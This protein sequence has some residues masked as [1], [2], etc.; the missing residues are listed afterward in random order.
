MKTSLALF[1]LILPLVVCAQKR[2]D[3]PKLFSDKEKSVCFVGDSITH[4]GYYPKHIALYYITRYPHLEKSFLNAGFEGGSANTTNLRFNADVASKKAQIYTVMLGM[5]DVRHWNFTPKALADRKSH[6]EKKQNFFALYKHNMTKLVDSLQKIGKVVLLSSSIYDAIGDILD[7]YAVM[8]NGEIIP[9]KRNIGKQF[10]NDELNRYGQWCAQLAKERNL[11]FA[12]HWRETNAA[13]IKVVAE[14]PHSS[15]IGRNRVHPF[16]F[17]GFFTA[18]AF[19]KDL[20]ETSIVSSIEL[21]AKTGNFQTLNAEVSEISTGSWLKLPF[22]SDENK[23]SFKSIEYALPYPLT[24]NTHACIRYCN[25]SE[26]INRQILRVRNLS[27]GEY[28]LKIDGETVGFYTS[29]KLSEGINL[30]ENLLTA[31]AE[32]S[33]KVEKQVEIWRERTQR[34]RDLFGTE[35]IMGVY[36]NNNSAEKN[37]EIAKKWLSTNKVSKG[38]KKSFLWYV[39]N[40]KNKET[41]QAQ[42]DKAL[43]NAYELAKPIPHTYAITKIDAKKY[44]VDKSSSKY[45]KKANVVKNV[46]CTD[47]PNGPID[48]YFS[49]DASNLKPCVIIFYNNNSEKESTLLAEYLTTKKFTVAKARYNAL[50]DQFKTLKWLENNVQKYGINIEKI[51]VC[52]LDLGGTEALL[53]A[54]AA[55]NSEAFESIVGDKNLKLK[56]TIVACVSVSS[57][58]DMTYPKLFNKKF[59]CDPSKAKKLSSYTHLSKNNPPTLLIHGMFDTDVEPAHTLQM[60]RALKEKNVDVYTK[61]YNTNIHNICSNNNRELTQQVFDDIQKFLGKT[62]N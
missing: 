19:L 26:D 35:F 49:A 15:A 31:Q 24:Q 48:L 52:A 56:N 62:L 7:P 32:Q 51:S 20:G 12:D 23:I 42:A 47:T 14:N 53:L 1:F 34:V 9:E 58:H 55:N 54:S 28:E 27:E 10:V 25:F 57:A 33:R 36:N 22:I 21:D 13:N 50:I 8:R 29:K 17:G 45:Q 40:R 43:K 4:H 37:I 6:E 59:A 60:A 38:S 44:D 11:L 39:E 61:F 46:K 16:D 2:I 3:N 18:Y 5:N 30:G 41:F